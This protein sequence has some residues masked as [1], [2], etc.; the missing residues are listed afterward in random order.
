[1]ADFLL[2]VV[3]KILMDILFFFFQAIAF[4]LLFPKK[5]DLV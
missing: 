2:W 1:M 5:Y 4:L 3:S